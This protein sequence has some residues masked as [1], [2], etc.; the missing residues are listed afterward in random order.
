MAVAS[1]IAGNPLLLAYLTNLAT[2]P[3]R[4][5]MY[6]SAFFAA[7]AEI[8]AGKFAGVAPATSKLPPSPVSEKQA[9]QQQPLRLVQAYL[10]SVGINDRAFKM[11]LYGGF[12]SA[13]L[14]HVMTGM[15]QRA[16]AG[17]TSTKDKILQIITSNLT[18]SVIANTVY[19]VC[20][21]L[22][23]GARGTDQVIRTVKA[24]WLTV[25]KLSWLTSPILI[26]TAQKY[27]PAEL[28]EPFF[29][30][31]RFILSTY[32]NTLAKKKQMAIA[33]AEQAKAKAQGGSIVDSD[34][35]KGAAQG[36]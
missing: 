10:E 28:W 32:F 4:T 19:L 9:A 27:L 29:T 30:F 22:I 11:A 13:P 3:L 15:L 24:S 5:K 33:R 18:A 12:I 8:L 7:L 16:F 36:K 35:A 6:T 20:L 21:S 34:L 2:N 25:M 17:R 14:G 1:K 26:A 31:A 23:N